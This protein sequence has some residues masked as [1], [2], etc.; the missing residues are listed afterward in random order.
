MQA[1]LAFMELNGYLCSAIYPE[2]LACHAREQNASP[3][4]HYEA[5]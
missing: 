2:R 4:H 3:E 1:T 5:V